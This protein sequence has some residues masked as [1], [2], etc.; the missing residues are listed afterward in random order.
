MAER[1]AVA[2]FGSTFDALEAE[3]CC[4]E[5]GVPGRIIPLPT[6]LSAECGLAW[7][8]PAEPSAR[9]SFE[10]ACAGRVRVAA[11]FELA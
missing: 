11:W 2:T 5:A 3:R 6:H 10:H 4:R 9:A 7:R 8:M 1:Y